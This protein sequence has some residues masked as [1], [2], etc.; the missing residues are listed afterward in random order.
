MKKLPPEVQ[1]AIILVGK[2]DPKDYPWKYKAL[3]NLCQCTS[4]EAYMSNFITSP[5]GSLAKAVNM[6]VWA[7]TLQGFDFWYKI[8]RN[9]P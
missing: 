7:N 9:L 2:L 5:N 6:F 3:N 4:K 8:Q 1:E